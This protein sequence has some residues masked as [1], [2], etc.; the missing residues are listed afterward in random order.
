M[1]DIVEYIC[2][3][4][5]YKTDNKY[6]FE[7]HNKSILHLTGKKKTR[8]D[9]QEKKCQYCNYEASDVRSIKSHILNLHKTKDDR[10]KEYTHYCDNCDFGSFIKKL[11]DKHIQSEKHKRISGLN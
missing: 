11:Y 2:E 9:C 4:C 3:K 6:L 7:R 8:S 10:R 5:N 1:K